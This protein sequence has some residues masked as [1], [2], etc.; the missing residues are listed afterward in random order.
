MGEFDETRPL[1]AD[2]REVIAKEFASQARARAVFGSLLLVMASGGVA[3]TVATFESLSGGAS[4]LF[5]LTNLFLGGL[6][7]LLVLGGRRRGV[8]V[9]QGFEA[10]RSV[11]RC[12]TRVRGSGKHRRTDYYVGSYLVYLRPGWQEFW[13]EGREVV[14]E[15][16]FPPE[17]FVRVWVDASL[18]SLPGIN[19]G[20]MRRIPPPSTLGGW[21]ALWGFMFLV[22]IFVS[23]G[24]G[25]PGYWGELFSRLN[26]SDVR[27]AGVRELVASQDL[28]GTQVTVAGAQLVRRPSGEWH[29]CDLSTEA[30]TALG[31]NDK[32]VEAGAPLSSAKIS[33]LLGEECEP[34][35]L[36]DRMEAFFARDKP[37]SDETRKQI[38]RQAEERCAEVAREKA[39]HEA[40]QRG[41]D[42][43]SRRFA[44]EVLENPANVC[45]YTDK[46]ADRAAPNAG[47]MVRRVEDESGVLRALAGR[48]QRHWYPG[49]AKAPF[50]PA[51]LVVST[52]FVL[53]GVT[54]RL[55]IGHR[56]Y[57]QKLAAWKAAILEDTERAV[58]FKPSRSTGP[59][60]K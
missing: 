7:L 10:T 43:R 32:I 39:K 59:H 14:V 42:E 58:L 13:P 5:T 23:I 54:L 48:N 55:G 45:V 50:G 6:G 29:L 26:H 36:G 18:V 4:V 46:P 30:I 27:V 8:A 25:Y 60:P 47:G 2:E 19:V 11:A 9:P 40:W 28:W 16:C 31:P 37:I 41:H 24:S 22:T 49:A 12:E 3:F 51:I 20:Q 34:D 56:R 33:A 1:N 15:L 53:A 21:G 44:F 38:R 57:K 17:R 35:V 52:V